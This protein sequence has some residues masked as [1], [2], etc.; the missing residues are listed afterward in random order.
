MAV[1]SFTH[2]QPKPHTHTFAC[3]CPP[4]LLLFIHVVSETLTQTQKTKNKT[5]THVKHVQI[6]IKRLIRN[7]SYTLTLLKEECEKT[8]KKRLKERDK[9]AQL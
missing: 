2:T 5:T 9:K 4:T 8:T 3:I 7:D 6:N 1:E